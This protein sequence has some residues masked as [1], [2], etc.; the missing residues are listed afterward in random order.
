MDGFSFP[1]QNVET[2][3]GNGRL[4]ARVRA[5][6]AD[7]AFGGAF[8]SVRLLLDGTPVDDRAVDTLAR[9]GRSVYT[10]PGVATVTHGSAPDAMLHAIVVES[11][12]G[13]TW[14]LE[15]S[16]DAIRARAGTLAAGAGR[17]AVGG[18]TGRAGVLGGVGRLEVTLPA[19]GRAVFLVGEAGAVTAGAADDPAGA[20]ARWEAAYRERGLRLRTPDTRLDLAVDFMKYHL[21]LGYDWPE[22]L[23]CDVFRWRDVWSRDFGSG[24]GP[25]ALAA[26]M[27]DAVRRTLDYEVARYSSHPPDGLKVS[28]DASQGGS[29]ESLGWLMKLVWRVYKYSGDDE[30]LRRT[31]DVFEPWMQTWLAR[32]ADED[33]LVA[34]VTEWMDHSRFLRLPEGQ[35]TLYSNVLYYAA[36]RRFRL[37]NEALGDDDR[38]QRYRDLSIRTR[39]AIHEG[40]WNDAGY[41]D[42]AVAWGVRD[43]AL[44]LADNALAVVEEV[45]SRNER[46]RALDAIHDRCW[47]AFGSVT[48]DVPMRYV[49]PDNDHNVRVWPWWMAHEAKARF[50]NGDAGGALTVVRKIL[51]TLERP[52]LPG[53]C[54]EYLHPD[55]GAQDDV[56]GHAFITGAGATLDALLTGLVG[57]T[58]RKPGERELR[59][60]PSVPRDWTTWEADVALEQGQVQVAQS[61]A[62]MRLTFAGTR[63]ECVEV[64]VPPRLSLSAVT[65]DGAP[66]SMERVEVGASVYVRVAVPNGGTGVVELALERA[67]ADR[68]MLARPESLPEPLAAGAPALMDEP[69]LFADVLQSFVSNAVAYFGT[70]R[71]VAPAELP[72]LTAGGDGAGAPGLVIVVG[73]ELPHTT[74]SGLLVAPLLD[75]H[76]DAGGAMLFLGPRFPP[77]D[78]RAD[79]REPAQMGGR[80][81]MF[82]WKEKKDGRWVDRDHAA[83]AVYWGDGPLFHAWEHRH[84]LFGFEA[85]CRGV[86]DVEG[87]VVDG[88][89]PVEVVYTDWTVRRPW[90]FHPLAFTERADPLITGPRAERYPCA[91]LLLNED[92]GARIAVVA[93]TLCGRADLL[94]RVLPHVA[95]AACEVAPAR[96]V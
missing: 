49:S 84:G 65:A 72:G 26:G 21:Q 92:T 94:H 57:L 59:I 63:V 66:A 43:T 78:P 73:N 80:A 38:A 55:T 7:Y 44:M 52:T 47:R 96:T 18:A 8:R 79:H 45:A 13:G 1:A 50:L 42:N 81:G 86:F 12:A 76:L 16:A 89:Q 14:V 29:A 24:V 15:A 51:D 58:H 2:V 68:A 75:A 34:D 69:R 27:F 53:L 67:P 35:R 6:A 64:R 39:R 25:G 9:P 40:F 20:P 30:W 22:K 23:V 28:A 5:G 31:R 85:R 48:C 88:E 17:V 32:D 61:P 83:G 3:V 36:L 46:F 33:G 91:V 37:I 95:R 71:H 19:A 4:I 87:A 77:I 41:F 90:T 70:V 62:A 10:L 60:A 93:P 56:V 74:E 11:E 54:E 82:W